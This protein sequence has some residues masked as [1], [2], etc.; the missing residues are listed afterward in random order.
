MGFCYDTDS[1]A[2]V[3]RR[4]LGG[5]HSVLVSTCHTIN[6]ALRFDSTP[7]LDVETFIVNPSTAL[8]MLESNTNR[9]FDILI[10]LVP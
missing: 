6:V 1:G 8:A 3:V 9:E 5:Y 2:K 10:P 4:G 7:P